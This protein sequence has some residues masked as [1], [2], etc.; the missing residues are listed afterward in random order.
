MTK[1]KTM[2][3]LA[4]ALILCLLPTSAAL[5]QLLTQTNSQ[6]TNDSSL[7]SPDTRIDYNSLRQLLA[8]GKWRRANN[9]TQQ[10]MLQATNR[11]TQGW[12]STENIAEFPCWDLNKIDSL[13]KEYSQGRFGF[14]VQFPI[15]IET[16]NRPGRLVD[17]DAY[18]K[19]GDRIGW[20]K[21]QDNEQ[22]WIDFKENLTY[23][24]NAPIGHLPNPRQEYQINGGRLEYVTL[25]NRML[26]CE[27]VTSPTNVTP[28][29]NETNQLN[30]TP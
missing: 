30:V 22:E 25:A 21:Q 14:S 4:L 29:S 15:F 2:K 28:S 8:A 16:G 17:V 12:I 19:F 7:V 26:T 11:E 10:L 9:R 6:P 23:N 1:I 18:E 5:G 27:L 3:K 24:L 20:R 13:W